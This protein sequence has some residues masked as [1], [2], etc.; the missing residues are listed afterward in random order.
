M[1]V[2]D[3]DCEGVV[4]MHMTQSKDQWRAVV[5]TAMIFGFRKRRGIS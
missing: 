2:R 4:W 1:D 5:N 3:L